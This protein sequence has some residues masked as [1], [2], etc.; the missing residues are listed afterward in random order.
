MVYSADI[1][2]AKTELNAGSI[3][4]HVDAFYMVKLDGDKTYADL[5]EKIKSGEPLT[6]QDLMNIVFVPLMKNSVDKATRIEQVTGL[7]REIKEVDEQTQV[8]AMIGLLADKFIG[9]EEVLKRIK[10]LIGMGKIFEMMKEDIRKDIERDNNKEI[11]CNLLREGATIAFAQKITG[12]GEAT[13]RQ[14]QAEMEK[15]SA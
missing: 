7:S 12:L 8:Q 13:V 14:L 6:K 9:D 4:Y 11:A 1:P 5:C 10:E 2:A 15:Q 3:E